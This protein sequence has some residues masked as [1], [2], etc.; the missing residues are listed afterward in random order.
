MLLERT[1]TIIFTIVFAFAIIAIKK[2]IGK[3]KL[4]LPIK[5]ILYILEIL[6]FLTTAY[7]MIDGPYWFWF[8][9]FPFA[10]LYVALFGDI[11]ATPFVIIFKK[12]KQLKRFKIAK[13]ILPICLTA[14][15]LIFGMVNMA[16]VTPNY[17]EYQSNKVSQDLNFAFISDVHA[18]GAQPP[19]TLENVV[20]QVNQLNLDFVVLGGDITDEY[21]TQEDLQKAYEIL[22]KLNAKTYYVYGN[23]DRQ[24]DAQ[25]AHGRQYSIEEHKDTIQQ[26]GIQILSDEFVNINADYTILGREDYSS[27]NR[28][29]PSETKFPD[30]QKFK[31]TFDH[32]PFEDEDVLGLGSDLQVSGHSHAGQFW[33]MNLI[34]EPIGYES[35]GEYQRGNTLLY[36]STGEAGW[37]IPLRTAKACHYEVF[38]IKGNSQNH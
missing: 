14:A 18:F 13:Y 31:I 12:L 35:N 4:N 34:E 28:K 36:V 21:S 17:H 2:L 22:G 11:V 20:N 19:E 24:Y 3:A 6:L 33:P 1:L 16:T 5:I 26:N 29:A 15:F 25:Y 23:H 8:L 37:Q 30:T 10:G 32:N 38:R 9:N 7:I 27:G